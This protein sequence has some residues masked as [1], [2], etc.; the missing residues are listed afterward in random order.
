MSGLAGILTRGLK[1]KLF[2]AATFRAF[3][4]GGTLL[5]C[6]AGDCR[7]SSLFDVASITKVFTALI[8]AK[9]RGE[10][11]ISEHTRLGELPFMDVPEEKEGITLFS[12]L[13]HTSGLPGYEPFFRDFLDGGGKI[14]PGGGS[15]AEELIVRAI[16]AMPLTGPPGERILYSDPG[17][18]LLGHVME[19]LSGSTLDRLLD[20]HISAPLGLADTCFLPLL[21]LPHCEAGRIVSTGLPPEVTKERV[22]EVWD[23]NCAVLGGVSGHAGAFSTAFDLEKLSRELFRSHG[24]S[25]SFMRGEE[26]AFLMKELRDS[27]GGARRVGFDVPSKEKSLAG[28]YFSRNSGGH[29]GYTG[30]SL[31]LDFDRYAGMV[32]LAN[33]VY[34]D[35]DM[36]EFNALRREVHDRAWEESGL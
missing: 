35:G 34:Y 31:W 15:A 14:R 18:I 4:L 27:T 2:Q 30:V 12:L 28:R 20:E 25:G 23:L 17:Y 13:C 33:R 1:R 7:G 11:H 36:E 3:D 21:R 16:L 6:T 5:E 24:G 10:G 19:Q 9:L 29:L 8:F 32:F 22:G 26:L